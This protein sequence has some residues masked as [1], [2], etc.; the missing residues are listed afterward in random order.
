[1]SVGLSQPA[2]ARVEAPSSPDVSVILPCYRAADVAS[3]SI[4]TLQLCLPRIARSWEVIVVD[5]GGGDFREAEWERDS[6]VR[7]LRLPFNQGKGAAVRAGLLAASGRVR[8]FTDVDLP[9]GVDEF[10]V[11]LELLGRRKLHL[12]IGDRTLPRSSYHLQIGLMR[13]LASSVFSHFVGTMV[14]GGFFDTQ[15][16]LKAIRGDVADALCP[17]LIVNRFAFDVEL[18]YVALR[19][20]LDVKAIPVRLRNNNTSSVRLWSDSWRSVWDVLR[21]KRRQLA[22]GYDVKALHEIVRADYET[23]RQLGQSNVPNSGTTTWQ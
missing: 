4:Q 18:L 20:R 16:G 21:I 17:H 9:F 15:C 19:H 3:A 10:P 23:I 14:T 1:V 6:Q 22:G 7:L 8:I 5:D 13:R 12:V 11:I 2:G